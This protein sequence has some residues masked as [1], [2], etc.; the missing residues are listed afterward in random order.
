MGIGMG[1]GQCKMQNMQCK[2]QNGR[3]AAPPGILHFA[4][5]ILHFAF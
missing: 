1:T 2:M 5:F 4:L 3:D